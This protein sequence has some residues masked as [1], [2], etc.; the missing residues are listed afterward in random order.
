M[1]ASAL[2]FLGDSGVVRW[3]ASIVWARATVL[4]LLTA[5]ILLG[6]RRA[7][8]STR[9]AVLALAA[10]SLLAL[11][12][13]GRAVPRLE[14]ALPGPA[15]ARRVQ[16]RL[17][18]RRQTTPLPAPAAGRTPARAAAA[19]S[20][21]SV[22]DGGPAAPTEAPSAS[23]EATARGWALSLWLLLAWAAGAGGALAR[24]AWAHLLMTR[25][26]RRARAVVDEGWLRLLAE[27]S[28][29]LGLGRPVRL[30][31]DP[32]VAVPVA[33]GY[34]RAT[35]LLPPSAEAW[36]ESRRR[37][38][39][40]HELAHVKRQD[41]L[42][43]TIALVVRGLYWP[44]PLVWWLAAR[45]RAE[46]ERSC[47]DMVLS[48]GRVTAPEYAAHLLET[49]RDLKRAPRPLAV[50]A[51]VER[52]PLEARLMALLD[53]TARRR[54]IGRRGVTTVTLLS[55]AVAGAVAGL[56]P[57]ARAA[58]S[59]SPGHAGEKTS[60]HQGSPT[61][62]A[63]AKA[64]PASAMATKARGTSA[65]PTIAASKPPAP[66]R[67][68]AKEEE[69][70]I[71]GAVSAAPEPTALPVLPTAAVSGRVPA[72][73]DDVEASP[74]VTTGAPAAATLAAPGPPPTPSPTPPVPVIRISTEV[75][76]IDAVVSDK[77]GR[78]VT[79]LR[80]EDFEVFENGRRK[81]I[82]H[83]AYV[84]TG[85]GPIDGAG[86]TDGLSGETREPRT[87][88]F[89]FDD[90][91]LSAASAIRA[92]QLLVDFTEH[93]V[94]ANDRVALVRTGDDR[95]PVSLEWGASE[96]RRAA[97]PLRYNSLN[98]ASLSSPG[99]DGPRASEG[100]FFFQ[101]L[102]YGSLESL[103]ATIDA[104]RALPGRKAVV[105]LSEGFGTLIGIDY[106]DGRLHDSSWARLNALYE[107]TAVR[108]AL[109]SLTGLANRASVVIYAIDPS[110]LTTDARNADVSAGLAA[111]TSAGVTTTVRNAG[112]R[113]LV[114]RVSRQSSLREIAG[115]TGG[116][117]LVNSNDLEAGLDRI[118]EDQSGY[119]L[120]AYEP[121]PGTFE[122]KATFHE[123][124]V[125]VRRHGLKVRS[126]QGFYSVP[127]AVV[128]MWPPRATR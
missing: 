106:R 49:A 57:V 123:L 39:L 115:Q 116:L 82:T 89:V 36:P 114:T 42:S 72:W 111:S 118:L 6:L 12:V 17:P 63:P 99:S 62:T 58:G 55:L 61:K 48:V 35:I 67:T 74:R 104:L 54:A 34:R 14:V 64:T 107:D 66:D 25:K 27:V 65:T 23:S 102:T 16:T 51:V 1:T 13:L 85:E 10:V 9:H 52:S 45:L 43:Q 28:T 92:R 18:P 113:S 79:N 60:A 11:P 56:Q 126:R 38:V 69:S 8:A 24:L 32:T 122:G 30:L 87:M 110:G 31:I 86:G 96:T 71:V 5:G 98:R 83:L 40:L 88:V 76:Q 93:G 127:D 109:N 112:Q 100:E 46:A 103:K 15:V 91:G 26:T 75:V 90:L 95:R 4:L 70:A 119:Y 101:R 128:A 33:F 94:A 108:A 120:L 3:V 20:P 68:R 84:R 19:P 105:F 29:G 125:K 81:V 77:S 50:V 44:N 124:K 97:E 73:S 7:S 59:G 21:L 22:P 2:G 121:A 47:D 41:C 80:P 117:A 53:P 78:Q 37:A